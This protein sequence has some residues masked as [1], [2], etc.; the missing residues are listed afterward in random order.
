MIQTAHRMAVD[1]DML[2]E[3]WGVPGPHS[4]GTLLWLSVPL[5]T[6]KDKR[7]TEESLPGPIY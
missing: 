7:E 4:L 6:S 3:M 5:M 2:S 1:G